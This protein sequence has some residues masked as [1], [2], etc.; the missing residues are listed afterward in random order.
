MKKQLFLFFMAL[1]TL[2]FMSCE[3][4]GTGGGLDAPTGFKVSQNGNTL[5]LEW[6]AVS[7]AES[8]SLT[9][10]DQFWQTT[11]ATRVVDENPVNGMNT[12]TLVASN[13]DNVSSKVSASYNFQSSGQGGEDPQEET[14]YIKHPWN[15]GT[16]EWK[17][18]QYEGEGQYSYR[19]C[20]WGGTGANINTSASDEGAQWFSSAQIEGADKA[21]AGD[22]GTFVYESA[23]KALHFIV[24][25]SGGEDPQGTTYYIKHPWGSGSDSSWEWQKMTKSGNS[26]T[27]TGAWGGIGANINSSADDSGAEWYS[28]ENISG[29]SSVSV[30][31]T[32]TFTF[33]PTNGNIGTLSVSSDGGGGQSSTLSAPTGFSLTQTSSAIK[34]SWNQVSGAIGYAIYRALPS[35][36]TYTYLNAINATSYTDTDVESGQTYYYAVG[37]V[38]EDY[39]VG[40]L[41]EDHITFNGSGGG[42]E[43]PT[44]PATPSGLT[45]TAGTSS[46]SLSWNSV[47]GATSYKVYRATSASG[48]Y[49]ERDN[50]GNT[51]Y[52][53]YDVTKGTTYYYKVT[54]L[55]SAGAE[56]AKSSAVSAKIASSSGGSKPSTPSNLKAEASG[57][58]I[59]LSWNGVSS[60]SSY[61]VYRSTSASGSYSQ[62]K[63][64]SHAYTSDCEVS[65]GV[66]YY[67]KVSAKNSYGES[68]MSSY[69]SASIGSS[70]GGGTTTKPSAPTGLKVTQNEDILRLTW[71]AVNNAT[72]YYIYRS[73]S[74]Y[75]G[76]SLLN[77]SYSNSYDDDYALTSGTTYYYK[78]SAVNIAGE[79]SQSSA[80]YCKYERIYA[81]CGPKNVDVTKGYSSV[82][83]K[84]DVSSA[85]GCGRPT[86]QIVM[87]WNDKKLNW[88]EKSPYTSSTGGSYEILSSHLN[89]YIDVLSQ[90]VFIIK[91]KNAK[92]ETM[93]EFTYNYDEDRITHYEEK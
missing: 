64:T 91:L 53:D 78:V 58:C 32:V 41:A 4:G 75:S 22:K 30:G 84:W 14:Y 56:S 57:S 9:K 5:V 15:G 20:Y 86:E 50:V 51:S 85:T 2:G 60:A 70:G 62:L 68:S 80:A 23:S 45:A 7:G 59:A 55:N 66:T 34:L 63:E 24:E 44:A 88:E 93:W 3:K 76:Y 8:Y 28:K 79:S 46:I 10:N 42:G 17:K 35:D 92:G 61:V 67:Y 71:N 31:A 89:D 29:A 21:K 77:E 40:E 25:S 39:Q 72:K 48:N 26:Y 74:Q 54:A 52:T 13:G 83:I 6:K 87:L 36:D 43:T 37:A 18:M 1:L 33:T 65:S 69:V 16:W 19:D 49:S 38:N 12:Y 81:P 90:L 11:S 82:K 27:Y 73:T 47:S